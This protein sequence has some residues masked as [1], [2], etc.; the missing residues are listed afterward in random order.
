MPPE[1]EV[2]SCPA[3]R[4]L[5]RVPADWLGTPVQ[6]PECKARFTAPTR[7]GDRLGEATLL[8]APST[9]ADSLPPRPAPPRTLGISAFALMLLGVVSVASNGLTLATVLSDPA[10][11]QASKEQQAKDLAKVMGQ[12][13]EKFGAGMD[14][15]IL[16]GIMAWGVVCGLAS[17]GAGLAIAVRR[18]YWLARLGSIL[19]ILNVAGCCCVPGGIVGVWTTLLLRTEEA[20]SHF[21]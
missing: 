15:R 17:A 6:C 16:A 18:W 1:T 11:F 19:A 2:I 13:P 8:D 4:H 10:E 14:W 20:R 9:D 12:D 5:V 21:R 3:C 7:D